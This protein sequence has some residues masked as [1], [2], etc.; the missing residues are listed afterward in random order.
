MTQTQSSVSS[1]SWLYTHPAFGRTGRGL[2]EG[3]FA[4]ERRDWLAILL[5]EVL[6]NGLDASVSQHEPVTVTIRVTSPRT[7]GVKLGESLVTDEH[8]KRLIA[9]MQRQEPE[10]I[11]L[12]Q[13][14]VIEDFGTSGLIGVTDD[15]DLDSTGQNWNAFWFREG[16]GGKEHGSGN[17]GAGQGKITYFS[18]SQVRTIFTYT[19]TEVNKEGALFGASSF[20]RD[21]SYEGGKYLRDAYWGMPKERKEALI[22]TP[23][24]D[25]Q[26]VELLR[27]ELGIKRQKGVAGLSL[28]IPAPKFFDNFSAIKITIAEF[29]APII[30]GNLVVTI[31]ETRIDK[32]NVDSLANDF[33]KDADAREL[34]TCTTKGFRKFYTTALEYSR[35]NKIHCVDA[36]AASGQLS[37][38]WFTPEVLEMLRE[39]LHNEE[40]IAI[41]LPIS[42]K[43]R[44]GSPIPSTFDVHLNSLEELD[45]PEQAILRHNLLIGEEPIGG[46]S[47]RQRARG[48]TIISDTN[49]S[50]LLLCA[51]EPT[52]L[53][54][55]TKLARLSEYYKSGSEVVSFV[56][57]AMAKLLDI[58]TA[59]EQK[60]DFKALA[61]Y[62]AVPGSETHARTKGRKSIKG[63]SDVKIDPI[64]TAAP[65]LLALV[66]KPDG[67]HV[68]ANKA[69]QPQPTDLPIH[70]TLEFAYE[71]LDKDA[72]AEYDQLDFDVADS[73]FQITT[74]GCEVTSRALN[75][76]EFKITQPNFV[77]LIGGFDKNLRLR[78]RLNYERTADAALID[79]E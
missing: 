13:F 35:L 17:G 28:I 54:W 72:F 59:S 68:T 29:Y 20:P 46:G 21:Y 9:S 50:R 4:K 33:L 10:R 34:H 39:K 22:C 6:Q 32:S 49:L 75:C 38:K 58:L 60:R 48:L 47:L 52:H 57:N 27:S 43:P 69:N 26:L 31:G 16:E 63:K 25:I 23:S 66:S 53:R 73:M 55:N 74:D 67:C 65:K 77:F 71:G 3:N 18:T 76:I 45:R 5:R 79:T 44:E 56:R 24:Q 30:R 37:E 40:H 41:R 2:A 11:D 62:F 14:L 12:S 1:A 7:G 70:A 64:P 61:K 42:I 51:E 19:V 15:P 78:V 8:R 36:A